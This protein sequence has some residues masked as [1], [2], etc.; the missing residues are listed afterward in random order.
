MQA[1]IHGF[2]CAGILPSQYNHFSQF[3]GIGMVGS[4]YIQAGK[5]IYLN[6]WYI[7]LK[8][9][10]LVY[11]RGGY[12]EMVGKCAKESMVKAA[13]EVKGLPHYASEGEVEY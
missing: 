10:P 11:R 6:F 2:T 8:K 13:E 7:L 3:A 5:K 9:F 4:W 1:Y 12:I